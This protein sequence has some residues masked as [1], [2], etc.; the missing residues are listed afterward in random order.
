MVDVFQNNT[1]SMPKSDP[2]I[3]RVDM[4]QA[5]IGGRKSSLPGQDRSDVL[6]VSH[7]PN[8]GSSGSK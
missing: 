6:S 7:V 2:Q 4:D 5:D 1:K 8:A 3:V